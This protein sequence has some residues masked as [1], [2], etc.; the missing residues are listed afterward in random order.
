MATA[1]IKEEIQSQI[2]IRYSQS[3]IK[4]AEGH[5]YCVESWD[6]SEGTYVGVTPTPMA[7]EFN[8]TFHNKEEAWAWLVTARELHPDGKNWEIDPDCKQECAKHLFTLL[9]D[10]CINEDE[11]IDENFL[12]FDKGTERTEIWHWLETEFDVSIAD[13]EGVA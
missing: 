13:L 7:E 3:E 6:Q 8:Y 4:E 1:N 10:V 11:E 9:A 12:H 5:I 2:R